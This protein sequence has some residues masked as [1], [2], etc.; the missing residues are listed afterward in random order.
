MSAQRARGGP[1]NGS[2][3]TPWL[4]VDNDLPAE[5]GPKTR[6]N[7]KSEG[8]VA[9]FSRHRVARW[10]GWVAASAVVM[11]TMV[12][13]TPQAGAQVD[14]GTAVGGYDCQ[15]FGTDTICW[16]RGTGFDS[17]GGTQLRLWDYY[18]RGRADGGAAGPDFGEYP[19][20]RPDLDP[21][22]LNPSGIHVRF[23][24]FST[25]S[26]TLIDTL[27]LNP[28]GTYQTFS[29]DCWD[30]DIPGWGDTWRFFDPADDIWRFADGDFP[31]PAFW[32][33]VVT[34]P[35]DPEDWRDQVAAGLPA[36]PPPAAMA[37]TPGLQAVNVASWVWLANPAYAPVAGRA[38]SDTRGVATL[39]VRATPTELRFDPGSGDAPVSC[40]VD[41]PAWSPGADEASGC[42]YTYD[43][44]SIVTPG[45]VFNARV[46]VEWD[47]T[48]TLTTPVRTF[49]LDELFF[50]ASAF[51]AFDTN[52][53]ELQI[54]EVD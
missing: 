31:N 30:A 1:D 24:E 38:L 17:R 29:V 23:A 50:T 12:T 10:V 54:L 52:V 4:R 11:A 19:P 13:G 7:P 39:T 25:L 46:A 14:G 15:R 21:G 41:S 42:T 48:W 3:G 49:V 22:Q 5:A 44:P 9:G 16:G 51:T 40:P 34:P 20:D 8:P 37:P 28:T 53:D 35:I 43:L 47:Y 26:P 45:A 32:V 33:S 36:L 2:D 18:C 27:Q 6:E